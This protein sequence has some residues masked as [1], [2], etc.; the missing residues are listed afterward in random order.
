MSD[1]KKLSIEELHDWIDHLAVSWLKSRKPE[2]LMLWKRHED[3][4]LAR[5]RSIWIWFSR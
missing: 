5:E 1:P 3:E 4:R 2:F